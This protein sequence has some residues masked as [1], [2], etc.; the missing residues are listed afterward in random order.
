M[1]WCR[2]RHFVVSLKVHFLTAYLWLRLIDDGWSGTFGYA[3]HFYKYA[4]PNLPN[5]KYHS[6]QV[7]IFLIGNN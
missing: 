3:M 7:S 4:L 5:T 6:I 2:K 1:K